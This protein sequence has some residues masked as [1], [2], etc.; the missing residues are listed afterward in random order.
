M[1]IGVVHRDRTA[2]VRELELELELPLRTYQY[3]NGRIE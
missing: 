2:Y 3:N 1:P